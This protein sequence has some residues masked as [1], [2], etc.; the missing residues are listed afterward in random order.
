MIRPTL[1]ALI[2]SAPLADARQ[3]TD[4][5]PTGS[6]PAASQPS[7]AAGDAGLSAGQIAAITA[8][9]NGTMATIAVHYTGRAP[10]FGAKH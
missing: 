3:A 9:I 10:T 4:P 1:A 6:Q 5:W 8:K 7:S 2:L